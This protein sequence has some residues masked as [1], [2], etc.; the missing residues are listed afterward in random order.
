MD[1]KSIAAKLR[2]KAA[3]PGVT[4][5]GALGDKPGEA[6]RGAPGDP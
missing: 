5:A 2:A 1:R 4:R 6:E 3:D